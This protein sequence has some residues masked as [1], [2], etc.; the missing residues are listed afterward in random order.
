MSSANNDSSDSGLSPLAQLEQAAAESGTLFGSHLQRLLDSDSTPWVNSELNLAKWLDVLS[1]EDADPHAEA[2]AELYIMLSRGLHVL[3]QG[4]NLAPQYVRNYRS[5]L[6]AAVD[7]S[8]ELQRLRQKGFLLTFDEARQRFPSLAG[9]DRPTTINAMGCVI[10]FSAGKRKIRITLDCS[11]P[12]GGKRSLNSNIDPPP[13][14]LSSVRQAMA[15]IDQLSQ[16][17]SEEV[18]GFK[19]D[20]CDAF[21]QLACSEESVQYLGVEWMGEVLVYVRTPFGLSHLPSKFQTVSCAITRAVLRRCQKIGIATGPAP[22]YDHQQRWASLA[23]L[24]SSDSSSS[25]TLTPSVKRQRRGAPELH[26]MQYLDDF[27][28]WCSS[29]RVANKAYLVFQILCRELGV[30]LQANPLKTAPPCQLLEFLGVVFSLTDMSVSLSLERVSKMLDTLDCIGVADTVFFRDMQSILGVLVFASCVIPAAKPYMRRM[31]DLL[32]SCGA[33][34]SSVH[35]V[36]IT[37]EIR[38][39]IECWRTILSL[40]N[41][42]AI[43]GTISSPYIGVELYTDASLGGWGVYFGGRTLMGAW[44]SHWLAHMRAAGNWEAHIN[45]LEAVALLFGLRMVLPL[46]AGRGRLICRIDNSAVCGMLHKLSSRSAICLTVMKEIT[47]LLTVYGCEA[48]PQWI[49][50]EDNSASDALSRDHLGY[51][52]RGIIA[53][54]N[55]IQPDATWWHHLP[56]TRPDL[57]PLLYQER[58]RDPFDS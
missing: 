6:E 28:G 4:F 48:I 44:P 35:R 46:C 14:H 49:A 15:A 10:K 45:F 32:R 55:A 50:T 36:T 53:K 26:L 21:L 2:A 47:L 41:G 43:V 39:D 25:S 3:P 13:T 7:V 34:P 54:W 23:D 17:S 38:H 58:W 51:D 40:L 19:L 37:N 42:S 1:E 16:S 27:A 24:P 5:A 11:A 22:G 52:W 31:F 56:P 30:P 57:L 18:F 20:I 29:L 33:R 8:A 12:R 9:L